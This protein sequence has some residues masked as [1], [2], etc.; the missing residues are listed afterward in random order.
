MTDPL[1]V[2]AEMRLAIDCAV[3]GETAKEAGKEFKCVC[4]SI[5]ELKAMNDEELKRIIHESK[6]QA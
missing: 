2:Q 6:R 4:P 1:W 5:D 3:A